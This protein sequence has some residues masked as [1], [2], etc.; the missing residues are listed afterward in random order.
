MATRRTV[1]ETFYAVLEDAVDGL[2]AASNISQEQPESREQLPT[3]VHTDNYRKVP[4]NRGNAPTDV[5]RD[6]NGDIIGEI[7][8]S[9]IEAQFDVTVLSDDESEKEDI[10]EAVR[11]YF[12]P[13]THFKS[14]R[15][16]QSDIFRVEVDDSSSNDLTDRN[17]IGRGDTL[18]VRL[19]FERH[20]T[21]DVTPVDTVDQSV[22]TDGDDIGE[23]SNTVT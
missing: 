20:Y 5:I 8:T 6:E 13:Y 23:I 21:K 10:Y 4:M 7:H 17:P 16:L 11:S 1:R 22:D 2:V 18:S 9:I 3:V 15:S 12:E 19:Q 14:A